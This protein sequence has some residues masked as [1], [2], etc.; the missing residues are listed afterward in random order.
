V[1]MQIC[2]KPART[3]SLAAVPRTWRSLVVDKLAP[4]QLLI[5]L[6]QQNLEVPRAPLRP[7]VGP[8]NHGQLGHLHLTTKQL[9]NQCQ[10]LGTVHTKQLTNRCQYLRTVHCKQLTNQCQYLRTVH[11]K[12]PMLQGCTLQ[13]YQYLRTVHGKAAST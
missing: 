8:V 10:Y 13:G 12:Q 5:G 2:H 4:R 3:L 11:C 7:L 6:L 1:K 9:T